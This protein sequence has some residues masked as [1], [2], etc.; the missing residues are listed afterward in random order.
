MLPVQRRSLST[1]LFGNVE[2]E[3][4]D[5]P[6]IAPLVIVPG[7]QLDKVLVQLNTGFGIEDGG[8]RVADEICGDDVLVGILDNALVIL[9]S[10]SILDGLFNFIEGSPLLKTDDEVDDRDI[11]GGDTEGKTAIN[12]RL[13]R[14]EG[15]I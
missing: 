5:T 12:R 1:V 2:Q 10:S 11:K 14:S 9:G 6:R 3:V 15:T 7:D 8:S 13:L 4:T